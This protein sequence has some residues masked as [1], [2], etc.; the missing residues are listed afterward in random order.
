MDQT[1]SLSR[2][3]V[4]VG[5]INIGP[6]R[7]LTAVSSIER[8]AELGPP[9][10]PLAPSALLRAFL[11]PNQVQRNGSRSRVAELFPELS[12][13]CNS[14]PGVRTVALRD[15]QLPCP[16]LDSKSRFT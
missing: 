3:R 11:F 16:V 6:R 10:W 13:A 14:V 12:C 8:C 1:T 7:D 15:L 2:F 5:G 9:P 4:T